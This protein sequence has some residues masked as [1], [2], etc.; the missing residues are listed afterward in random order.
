MKRLIYA[1]R[2]LTVIPIPYKEGED[3]KAVAGATVFYPFTG[4]LIG[5]VLYA[6]ALIPESFFSHTV[7]SVII[8]ALWVIITGGLHLDGLSDLTD[9]LGGGLT[10]ERKLEIMKDSRI[11][12]FGVLALVVFLMLKAVF[13]M[14]ILSMNPMV[15][16][17]APSAGRFCTMLAIL[18]FPSARETGMGVFFKQNSRKREPIIAGLSFILI[19]L[20]TC[21]ITGLIVSVSALLVIMIYAAVVSGILGGLTGDV[22]GSVIELTELAVLVFFTAASAIAGLM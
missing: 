14:E 16:L 6:A 4:L 7:T 3:M 20:L 1:I 2:F 5:A 15:L 22:Y 21:G 8:T 11:G 12:A 13:I 9:G 19:A 17:L 10:R 18:I